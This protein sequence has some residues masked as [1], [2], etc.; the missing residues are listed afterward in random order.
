MRHEKYFYFEHITSPTFLRSRFFA[1]VRL[2]DSWSSSPAVTR[3]IFSRDGQA[4]LRSS[5]SI[6][7][8]IGSSTVN[9]ANRLYS[10]ICASYRLIGIATV[11]DMVH[12]P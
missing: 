12:I 7:S 6:A 2:S 10:L 8:S 11:V 1:C 4:T 3:M 5:A 9:R